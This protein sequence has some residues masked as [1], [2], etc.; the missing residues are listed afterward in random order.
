MSD[1]EV[2][3]LAAADLTVCRPRR[4]RRGEKFFEISFEQNPA[5]IL[6]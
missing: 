6:R 2:W 1:R 4:L 3:N 5:F